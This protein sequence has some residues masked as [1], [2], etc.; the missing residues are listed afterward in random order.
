MHRSILIAAWL[1][2]AGGAAEA[3]QRV[4]GD[5]RALDASLQVGSSGTNRLEGQVDYSARNNVITGNVTDFSGFRGVINYSAAGEFGD[6]LGSNSLFRFRADSFNSGLGNMNTSLVPNQALGV[7]PSVA[8]D[9]SAAQQLQG[10]PQAGNRSTRIIPEGGDYRLYGVTNAPGAGVRLDDAAFEADG[11]SI[12]RFQDQAGRALEIRVSPLTGVRSL[13]SGDG[14]SGAAALPEAE[15]GSRPLLGSSSVSPGTDVGS[16]VL[17]RADERLSSQRIGG[18]SLIIGQQ[19]N[20]SV[21]GAS[22]LGLDDRTLADVVKSLESKIFDQ[23]VTR[24]YAP[25]EDVYADILRRGNET[26][27]APAARISNQLL[28]PDGTELAPELKGAVQAPSLDRVEA[29]EAERN[30]AMGLG[31]NPLRGTDLPTDQ[32]LR[33][34][35]PQETVDPEDVDELEQLVRR[36]AIPTQRLDTLVSDREDRFNQIMDEA[37]AQLGSGDY[38][39]AERGYRRALTQLPGHPMARVGLIH[40]QMAAGMIRSASANLRSLFSDHPELL[41]VRYGGRVL[42]PADRVNWIQSEL[43][44]S[45]NVTADQSQPGLL[46]AYLGFQLESRQL[47]RYGLAI[48]G[49]ASPGDPLIP[50]LQRLWLPE[51]DEPVPSISVE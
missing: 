20:M 11:S 43:Q 21:S 27:D 38:F 48:A 50:L 29:A 45:I 33:D 41:T 6:S 34:G 51:L 1:V 4:G 24:Q 49:G 42:P 16:S 25:G 19:L 13:R 36:L 18:S 10:I 7:T 46:L 5:G 2:M 17:R 32:A 8:R 12:A 30:R 26:E 28:Y 39:A 23:Q 40:A 44:R 37:Q 31:Q 15:P 9:F 22:P 35:T 47:V 3:Q 14:P